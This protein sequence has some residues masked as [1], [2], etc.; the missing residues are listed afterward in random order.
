[1]PGHTLQEPGEVI[2]K[3]KAL[4]ICG[5]TA[6]GKSDLSDFAGELLSESLA[7]HSPVIVVD[8]MQVYKELP[9]ITNQYRKRPAELTGT[10]SVSE[11]WTMALHRR[12]CDEITGNIQSPFVLDAGTGMYLNAIL[13]DIPIAPRVSEGLRKKAEALSSGDSN[14]RRSSRELELKLSGA[15][16]RGSIWDGSLRYDV[17]IIYLRPTREV[18]DPS[19][20]SRSSR[21]VRDGVQEAAALAES[22]PSGIPNLSVRESIGVKELILHNKGLISLKEAEQRILART[23]R[24]ARRQ[25]R[26]FDKLSKT[27]LDRAN[28]RVLEDLSDT[29]SYAKDC[30][31]RYQE[32]Y[33]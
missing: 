23:R 33:A 24:L 7:R 27:L 9:T 15:E 1:M 5:P 22:F 28:V 20:A 14:P 8:S 30:V 13:L 17:E 16:R 29:E 10:V 26:W 18:L 31:D 4:V 25:I 12:A 21:I 32:Y 2:Q 11:E 3:K 6:C 19:I